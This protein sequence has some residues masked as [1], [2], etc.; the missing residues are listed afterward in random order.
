MTLIL[1]V[2]ETLFFF[3]NACLHGI[4]FWF[5]R[6]RR[7]RKRRNRREAPKAAEKKV[8]NVRLL[9]C[10]VCVLTCCCCVCW[11]HPG[12]QNQTHPNNPPQIESFLPR[13]PQQKT[14]R[15][16]QFNRWNRND[17]RQRAN[18]NSSPR[19]VAYL[20]INLQLE[21]ELSW[22]AR[23]SWRFSPT[24]GFRFPT[25]A[26]R[27]YGTGIFTYMNGLNLW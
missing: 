16:Q 3:R 7:R 22:V 12:I 17:G 11:S 27:I 20:G 13:L 25:T 14:T 23:V 19:Y 26:H 21:P 4:H 10:L 15:Q 2:K 8:L 9:T 24:D 6:I 5:S 1:K 18:E